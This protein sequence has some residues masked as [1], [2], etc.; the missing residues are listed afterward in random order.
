MT[1]TSVKDV[2]CLT[3]K[4]TC[5]IHGDRYVRR[6]G[7]TVAKL[8]LAVIAP[9]IRFAARQLSATIRRDG[10]VGTCWSASCSPSGD[11]DRCRRARARS[12]T[13]LPVETEAPPICLATGDRASMVTEHADFRE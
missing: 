11:G 12:I 6:T 13:H 7:A 3:S 9:A 10:A 2:D 4:N 8:T 1:V 5:H